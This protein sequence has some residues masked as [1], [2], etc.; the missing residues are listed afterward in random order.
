MRMVVHIDELRLEDCARYGSLGAPEF[1]DVR[2][3]I[4]EC[5]SCRD[6]LAEMNEFLDFLRDYYEPETTLV[7]QHETSGGTV[8]LVMSGSDSSDWTARVIGGGHYA[9]KTFLCGAEAQQWLAR[10]AKRLAMEM[11]II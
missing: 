3:H 6:R 4:A 7:Q 1:T 2:E 10:W 11:F 8:F 9:V 5:P